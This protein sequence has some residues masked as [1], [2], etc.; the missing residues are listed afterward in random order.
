MMLLQLLAPTNARFSA[1]MPPPKKEAET[2]TT[3]TLPQL[4]DLSTDTFT[5]TPALRSGGEVV[6]IF[7]G[8]ILPPNVI[9]LPTAGKTIIPDIFKFTKFRIW[10]DRIYVSCHRSNMAKIY[11][12]LYS[13]T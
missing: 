1:L 12:G 11:A 6:G 3:A 10:Y 5:P 4:Q 13:K 2:P 8:E 9:S 7:T